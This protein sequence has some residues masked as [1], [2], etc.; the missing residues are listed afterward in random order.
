MLCTSDS[1]EQLAVLLQER[2]WWKTS[3]HKP[4]GTKWRFQEVLRHQPILGQ[5][6]FEPDFVVRNETHS[7]CNMQLHTTT[8][9]QATPETYN[10]L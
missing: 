9:S 10:I 1:A 5:L 2:T 6:Q 7:I 3:M 4:S 8:N